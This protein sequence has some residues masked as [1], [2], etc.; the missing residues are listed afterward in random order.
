MNIESFRIPID[1]TSLSHEF[2]WQLKNNPLQTSIY[3]HVFFSISPHRPE[4]P[5]N[6][7]RNYQ[8]RTRYDATPFFPT[9]G[10]FLFRFL[11]WYEP[12]SNGN[13]RKKKQEEIDRLTQYELWLTRKINRHSCDTAAAD[14]VRRLICLSKS[15]D[16]HNKINKKCNLSPLIIRKRKCVVFKCLKFG[17]RIKIENPISM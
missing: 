6:I 17:R 5:S 11:H 2:F 12:L 14:Y 16:K 9:C 8:R 1:H 7:I 4:I 13:W 15:S 10:D 3:I